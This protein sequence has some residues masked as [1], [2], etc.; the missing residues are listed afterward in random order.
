[1]SDRRS[2]GELSGPELVE[3]LRELYARPLRAD[4]TPS[5]TALLCIDMQYRTVD[6]DYGHG[7]RAHEDSVVGELL[8][9]YYGRLEDVLR[10][11]VRRLQEAFRESGMEVIHFRVGPQT[12]DG[13]ENSRRYRGMGIDA[14]AGSKDMEIPP[15]IGPRGDELVLSKITSSAFGSTDLDRILRNLGVQNVVLCGV[16]T[17]GCVETTARAAADLDYPAIVVEDATAAMERRIHDHALLGMGLSYADVAS[18]TDV[19]G[20]IAG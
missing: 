14:A 11:N 1:M 13:R 7:P 17:N 5:N 3:T 4:V 6:P 2:P 9:A 16:V 20:R 18:T 10:P 12:R 19:L 15:D 8:R